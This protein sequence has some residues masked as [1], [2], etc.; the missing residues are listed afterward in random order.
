M[1][2]QYSLYSIAS[3]RLSTPLF[4]VIVHH[5]T[6]SIDIYQWGILMQDYGIWERGDKTNH[7][8]PELN[9]SSVGMAKVILVSA[10][11]T[12]HSS[13]SC[14]GCSGGLE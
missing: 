13:I 3:A 6:E 4:G 10:T 9:T 2:V 1:V 12:G 11:G 5:S 8:L 14:V 7:G